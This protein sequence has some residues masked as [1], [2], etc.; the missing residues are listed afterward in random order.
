MLKI[1]A[2]NC[3]LST[4]LAK[5]KKIGQ[6]NETLETPGLSTG[7]RILELAT[8]R[9]GTIQ[10]SITDLF[11][12]M[13]ILAPLFSCKHSTRHD[14]ERHLPIPHLASCLD[15]LPSSNRF[16]ETRELTSSLSNR[17]D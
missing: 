10:L 8:G 7:D 9:G 2:S 16:S 5:R 15:F 11:P 13:L 12:A 4:N 6:S 1:L 17:S 3:P 14:M